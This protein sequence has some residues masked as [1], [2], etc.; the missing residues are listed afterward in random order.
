MHHLNIFQ[1]EE[2]E[3]EEEVKTKLSR[4]NHPKNPGSRQTIQVKVVLWL[5]S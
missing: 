1:E 2:E 5:A 3:E 4:S